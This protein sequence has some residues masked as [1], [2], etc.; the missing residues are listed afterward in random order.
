MTND[1][2]T[3]RILVVDDQQHV[4]QFVRGILAG[5]GIEQVTEANSGRAALAAMHEPGRTFDLALVDL[6]MADLDGVETIREM[7]RQRARCAVAIVSVE[8]EHVIDAVGSLAKLQ[9]LRFLG[10]IQKPLTADK[11]EPVLQRVLEG[12]HSVQPGLPGIAPAEIRDAFEASQLTVTFDPQI[13][14]RSGEC[15]SA[16]AVLGWTHPLRGT[17]ESEEFRNYFERI[18]ADA[19]RLASVMLHDAIVACAA[20]QRGNHP[21]GVS[22]PLSSLAF[23]RVDFTE[24][25]EAIAIEHHVLPAAVTIELSAQRLPEHHVALI[26]IAARLRIKGFRLAISEFGSGHAAMDFLD[27][28]PFSELKLDRAIVAGCAED[29][30]KR[31]LVE[32]SMALASRLRLR[33]VAV[34]V[35]N[36][37]EWNLLGQL[38][39][40]AAQGPFIAR[41]VGADDFAM[42]ITRWMM[43]VSSMR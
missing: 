40:D 17:L 6:K 30:R 19:K 7:S 28:V 3:L 36:R 27:E 32:A 41:P 2:S 9:G 42:W 8:D 22:I 5:M 12:V 18:P 25:I 4:R 21:A 14:I 29:E 26:D 23:D 10:A 33:T 37:P 13:N 38:G 35:A 24:Q 15:E 31:A 20:W 11:L 16:E 39:C 34:G 43:T 1:Y